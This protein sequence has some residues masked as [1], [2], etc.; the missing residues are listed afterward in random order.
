MTVTAICGGRTAM[1]TAGTFWV[2]IL[3][4]GRSLKSTLTM[5]L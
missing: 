5:A 2:T 3:C 4:P 1:V